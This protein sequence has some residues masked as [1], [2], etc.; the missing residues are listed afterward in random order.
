VVEGILREGSNEHVYGR[1]RRTGNEKENS[2]N[3]AVSAAR[4]SSKKARSR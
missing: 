3:E 1:V 4:R 2:I